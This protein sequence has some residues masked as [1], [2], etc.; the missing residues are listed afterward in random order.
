MNS[1]DQ[2]PVQYLE[3]NS[4]TMKV[5]QGGEKWIPHSPPYV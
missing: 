1:N 5:I 2:Q 3:V 4:N